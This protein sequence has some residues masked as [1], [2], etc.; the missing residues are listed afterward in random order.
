MK[1]LTIFLLSL[2][3]LYSCSSQKTTFANEQEFQSYLNDPDNGFISSTKNSEFILETKLEPP[4]DSET[5][6]EFTIHVRLSRKDGLPVLDYGNADQQQQLEREGYL[7][8]QVLGD[9]Y[10]Q[11]GEKIIPAVFQH[12]ERNYG[13]KPSIDLFFQFK[14]FTPTEDFTF[15]YR[16]ELFQQG[17]F[18][19]KLDK[20]LLTS[21]HVEH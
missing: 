5:D 21:C 20:Q 11:D 19:I 3:F 13:L 15:V 14:K 16:D 4:V 12:Y 10:I 17:M 9:V 8:F 1:Y 6:Q 2:V 18:K 7:S